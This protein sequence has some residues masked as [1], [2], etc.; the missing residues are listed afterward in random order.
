MLCLLIPNNYA[1]YPVSVRQFRQR[2]LA[3]LIITY[4]ILEIVNAQ[5]FFRYNLTVITLATYFD[6]KKLLSTH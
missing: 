5:H 4:F 6:F 2:S 3:L 1:S